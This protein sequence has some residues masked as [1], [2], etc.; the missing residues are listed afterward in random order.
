ME[1]KG[2]GGKKGGGG[3]RRAHKG[4]SDSCPFYG[5]ETR[6][7]K[8]DLGEG[9][10]SLL[11]TCVRVCC[12]VQRQTNA[13]LPSP[14][15]AQYAHASASSSSPPLWEGE[16]VFSSH[17]IYCRRRRRA[18]THEGGGGDDGECLFPLLSRRNKELSPLLFSPTPLSPRITLHHDGGGESKEKA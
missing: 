7:R 18:D 10:R 13:P 11:C 5:G 15:C 9:K 1:E 12:G 4:R 8:G 2:K 14:S 6:S 3:K 16:M 17:S